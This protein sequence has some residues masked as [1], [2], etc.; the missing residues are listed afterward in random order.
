MTDQFEVHLPPFVPSLFDLTGRTCV[1]TGAAAGISKAVALGFAHYGA[2]VVAIDRDQAGVEVTADLVRG[3]GRRARAFAA[4]VTNL[5]ELAEIADQLAGDQVPVDVCLAGVG[6]GLR[7][8]IDST[9]AEQFMGILQLN[10]VSTWNTAKAFS[11]L[12]AASDGGSFIGIASIFGHVGD[13]ELGAYGPAKAGVV[14][15][16]RIL[17]LEWASRNVRVN[18]LSP[19]QVLTQRVKH[20]L[21]D[22]V[23]Y[24]A[25]IGRSPFGRFG[26]PWELIGPAIFL[27]SRASSF[28]TGHALKVDGGWTAA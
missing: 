27:A 10:L 4:D 12:L 24:Q 19:S 16:T 18:C 21:D 25:A 3:L 22:P 23:K 1:V 11:D 13:G 17:A 9:T 8:S 5:E 6:G 14:Q 28:V 15:L 26:E 7:K 2:D 20:I